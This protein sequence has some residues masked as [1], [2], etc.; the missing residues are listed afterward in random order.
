MVALIA[1]MS[2]F[3]YDFKYGDLY[4]S[5]IDGGTAEV[6][7]LTYDSC[8]N[9]LKLTSVVIPQSV[10]HGG[11]TYR[12]IGIGEYAFHHCV[13]LTSITIPNSITIIGVFAFQNCSSLTSIAIPNS[14]TSI[15]YSAFENCSSLTSV[16]IGSSLKSIGKGAFKGCK[17]LKSVVW[18]AKRCADL[19][20]GDS[21]FYKQSHYSDGFDLRPQ[22]TSFIFGDS[23]QYIPAYICEGMN[24]LTSI[25]IPNS[26]TSIGYYAFAD[27]NG[28]T[29]LTVG[30]NVTS[31][32]S[33]VLKGCSG[34]TTVVWNVKNVQKNPF[35]QILDTKYLFDLRSQIISFTFGDSVQYI[36]NDLCREMDNLRS[37]IIGNGVTNIGNSAFSGCSSLTSITIPNSVKSIGNSAFSG[38]CGLTSITIPNNVTSIG[39]NA[40]WGCSGLTSVTIGNSV[41]SIGW[42]AFREC[43]GLTK[44]N[45]VGDVAGWYKIAFGNRQSN[46]ICYSHNFFLNNVLVTELV[47]PEEIK[48]INDALSQD[49]HLISVVIPNG[50]TMIGDGAFSGCGGLTSFTIPNSVTNIGNSAFSGCSSL[51]SIAIPNSVTSIG[52]RAFY[53]CSG[54]TSITIP[55]SVTSIGNSAFSGCSGLTSITIPNNVTSIGKTVFSG[56]S[57]LTSVVWN[58]S[59]YRDFVSTSTPFYSESENYDIRSQLSSFVFSDSV[60]YIPK[61]ICSGM[62]RLASVTIPYSITS[63]GAGAFAGCRSLMSIIWNAKDCSDFPDY[64]STPFYD[65]YLGD[66]YDSRSKI[67]SFI[68]GDSVRHIPAYICYEMN[69]LT[70]I[71]V[72]ASVTFVG[73]Y[74]FNGCDNLTTVV[75]NA[76]TC[77]GWDQNYLSPFYRSNSKIASFSFG[78]EVKSI[79][80]YLCSGMV[81]LTSVSIPNSVDSIGAEAFKN[82]R[83]LISVVMGKNVKYIGNNAFEGT[84]WLNNQRDGLIYINTILY[85]Y[86]GEIP[87]DIV[88]KEGT[89]GIRANALS[90]CSKITSVTI[91]NSVIFIGEHAFSSCNSLKSVV[92]KAKSYPNCSNSSETPFYDVRENITSFTLGNEVDTIPAYLCYGMNHIDSITIPNSVTSIG[93]NAFEGCN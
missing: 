36:P 62:N 54:L 8:C 22:I 27:C 67:T 42:D 57:S 63:V 34:L 88:V 70:D 60:R 14:V 74:A 31:F 58:V 7:Y 92:W 51:T 93:N 47:I 2:V 4:Y 50:V 71:T 10:T 44:T 29:S 32:E 80:N 75:W 66:S 59:N 38:C 3:A 89:T 77:A 39:D 90:D 46:P 23:V 45:Y 43:S 41:T 28:M 35:Y 49:N 68:F 86:K 61:Y 72:P 52:N 56:C 82:C 5:I 40:F 24:N 79:P 65:R 12:V 18:N 16:T 78:K 37:V 19:Y 64:D 6:S 84:Y 21:P 53:N 1:T 20:N 73:K 83:A 33:C 76:K 9:D 55:N 87:L 81:S 15:G 25:I 85:G 17:N 30:C 26:V 11:I 69:N 48:I 13:S 91:P